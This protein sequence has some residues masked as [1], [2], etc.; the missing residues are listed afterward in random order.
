ML[1]FLDSSNKTLIFESGD[2]RIHSTSIII[3]KGKPTVH[4]II[5][6]D[7]TKRTGVAFRIALDCWIPVMSIIDPKRSIPY[8]IQQV[9]HLLG[10]SSSIAHLVQVKKKN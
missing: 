7:A 10:I 4:V 3:E 9:Q 6:K 1:V 8:D 5:E 2:P